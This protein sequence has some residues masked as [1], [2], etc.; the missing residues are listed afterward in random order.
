MK[1]LREKLARQLEA[2][3]ELRLRRAAR[4]STKWFG[5]FR[6]TEIRL[7]HFAETSRYGRVTIDKRRV[8]TEVRCN[9]SDISY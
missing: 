9:A 3:P 2:D 4:S 5:V 8:G 1:E 7:H 6:I